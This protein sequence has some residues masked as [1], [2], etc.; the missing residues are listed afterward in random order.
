MSLRSSVLLALRWSA[1]LRIAS[2]VATW[3]MTLI[4]I[5]LLSPA[6]YGLMA[7]A[8]IVMAFLMMINELGIGPALVQ[9]ESL[10]DSILG[11]AFGIALVSNLLLMATVWFA[12]PLVAAFFEEPELIP[13][14]RLLSVQFLL[15]PLAVLPEAMLLRRLDLKKKSIV[16]LIAN[17]AGGVTGLVLAWTGHGVWSLVWGSLVLMALRSIGF[18]AAAPCFVKPE[19]SLSKAKDLL[20]FGALITADRLLWFLYS[21]ADV[22]I[23]GKILGTELLG[24]YAVAMQVASLPLQKVNSVLNEVAFPAFSRIQ[25]DP[26]QVRFYL[27]KATRTVS[28]LAFPIFFGISSVAPHFVSV[29]LGDQWT[30][31]VLPLATLACIMPLRMISNIVTSSLQ[32]IGRVGVSVGNLLYAS[33]IIPVAI[34]VGS[35]YG[36][37]GVCIAW[38]IAFPLVTVIEIVRSKPYIG[39]GVG[40]F[41]QVFYRPFFGSLIMWACV[42]LLTTYGRIF[43]VSV[44]GLA[45]LVVAGA[46]V[47]FVFSIVFNRT[48]MRELIDLRSLQS[49]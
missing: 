13:I 32:G 16:D 7:L 28:F 2:Q 18:I 39:M 8:S 11:Q 38:L 23:I 20:T 22:V 45:L 19:F 14:I 30:E 29:V 31:S 34:Y 27:S 24:I 41:V 1:G 37:L 42:D 9:R 35:G 46:L 47:Y 12:S 17:I 33:V 25:N 36:L 44:P 49:S 15:I 3:A 48:A 40:A 10:D 43:P 26:E 5:R 21:R 6:D 4:V